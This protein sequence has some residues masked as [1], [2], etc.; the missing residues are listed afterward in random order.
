MNL[1]DYH[2][3]T[4]FV[5]F[6]VIKNWLG[7]KMFKYPTYK[8]I[9]WGR[10]SLLLGEYA[11]LQCKDIGY[12]TPY[13]ESCKACCEHYEHDHGICYDRGED[14]TDS[15]YGKAEAYYEGDR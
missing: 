13:K 1:I 7:F 15:L 6:K 2:G 9:V 10:F 8:H 14:I 3:K 11:C 12:L 5:E 4:R